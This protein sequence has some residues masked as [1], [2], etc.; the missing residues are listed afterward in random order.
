[1]EKHIDKKTIIAILFATIMVMVGF[2]G[3]MYY[4]PENNHGNKVTIPTL[5]HYIKK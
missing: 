1:M 3:L 5:G 2:T 4:N